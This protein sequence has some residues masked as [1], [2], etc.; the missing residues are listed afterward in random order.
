MMFSRVP[1]PRAF[2]LLPLALLV[3]GTLSAKPPP[4]AFEKP[5]PLPPLPAPHEIYPRPAA[6]WLEAQIALARRDFSSGAI[7]GKVGAQT[8]AAL[9]AWQR[10]EDLPETAALD[11][12]TQERLQL[13]TPPLTTRTVTEEDLAMLLPLSPTWLGK[14]Q[15]TALSWETVLEMVAEQAHADPAFLRQINPGVDWDHVEPGAVLTIP[16]VAPPAGTPARVRVRSKAARVQIHLETR[17]LQA[18]DADGKLLAHFPVSIARNVEKRPVGELHVTVIIHRPDYTFDPATFPE[19]AEAR[20][21]G[22]KLIL[23]PGPNNPVGL[24]WVGLD[25]PGYGIHGT[26]EP[27]K[28]GRTESHGCFRLA[29]WNALALLDLVSVGTPVDVIE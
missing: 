14:S 5:P 22:R 24:A 11:A 13:D 17:T 1:C 4:I 27:E 19:S 29:N 26:P 28:V 21:L 8:L 2:R 20:E 7:D 25:R 6:N 23:P 10:N 15:Q 16:D 18:R 9:R 3:A 12:A